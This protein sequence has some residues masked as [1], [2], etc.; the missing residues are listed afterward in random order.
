MS[1]MM[2]IY[3]LNLSKLEPLDGTNYQR[4]SQRMAIFFKHLEVDYVF[5]N[6]RCHNESQDTL[7]KKYEADDDRVKKYV[8]VI[9]HF[10]VVLETVIQDH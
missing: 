8:I 3:L 6:P 10:L 4:W 9:A 7:E 2:N 5:F 1:I